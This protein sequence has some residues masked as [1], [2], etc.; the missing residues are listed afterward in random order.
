MSVLPPNYRGSSTYTPAITSYDL[1]AQ[2]IRRQLGEPL[3]NVE[4]ANVQIYE[5]IDLACEFFTKFAG[6]TEEYLIFR[7]DLYTPGVGLYI[8]KLFNITP[9]FFNATTQN[10]TLSAA[11]DYDFNEYRKVIDVFSFENGGGT[12]INNLFTVESTL[13]QQAYFGNML[14]GVGY[15]LVTFHMLK[16]YLDNRERVLSTK[17]YLRFDAN[18]QLLK[19]IPEPSRNSFY[20]GL[21]GAN[22][23]KPIKDIVSQLWVYRYALA[24]VKQNVAHVRGKYGGTN[25][26][27]GQL[28]NFDALMSQGRED[29]Q[30]LEDELIHDKQSD[31]QLMAGGGFVV[32]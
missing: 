16:E 31:G 2:R 32:G 1:L 13:A 18:R 4:A 6:T 20:Y 21:L 15:D 26:F 11:W 23:L 12:G 19:I 5:N 29:Q 7:S 17:P 28:V 22:V 30:K 27:G 25:L 24:L 9:E 14:G 10:G 8:D 3:I